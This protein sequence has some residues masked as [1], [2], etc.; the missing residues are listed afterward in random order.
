MPSKAGSPCVGARNAQPELPRGPSWNSYS[1]TKL[2]YSFSLISQQP[3]AP[4]LVRTPSFTTH[5]AA[6]CGGLLTSD[7]RRTMNPAGG[8]SFGNSGTKPS[9]SAADAPTPVSRITRA[10]LIFIYQN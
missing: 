10:N 3:R 1:S 5:E 6:S 9:D 4:S 7:Q 2:P 8:P